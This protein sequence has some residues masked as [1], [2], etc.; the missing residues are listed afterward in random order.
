[1]GKALS[2]RAGYEKIRISLPKREQTEHL[3]PLKC[4]EEIL[5][6]QIWLIFGRHVMSLFLS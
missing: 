1:M 4:T 2:E 6:P 3:L 5:G